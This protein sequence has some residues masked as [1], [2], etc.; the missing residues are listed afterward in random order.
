MIPDTKI[1]IALDSTQ[2]VEYMWCPRAWWYRYK[3]GLAL[4]YQHKTALDYGSII[5]GLLE[6]YYNLR[7]LNSKESPDIHAKAA[8]DMLNTKDYWKDFGVTQEEWQF[9]QM[10]YIQY[11][12]FYRAKGDFVPLVNKNGVPAVEL[13]FS[14]ILFE[15]ESR[16]YIV[17]GRIDLISKF[18]DK[19]F[20]TD[21]K[22]QGTKKDLYGFKTQFLTYAWAT[23]LSD[24]LINYVGTTKEP[25]K[26]TFRRQHINFP[27]HMIDL[28]KDQM[29]GIFNDIYYQTHELSEKA[30]IENSDR[31]FGRRLTSC[32][33]AF[34][35]NPCQYIPIC[36]SQTLEMK[37]SIK[38]F[39]FV[40][41]KIWRPW[42]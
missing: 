26:D 29:T 5:H 15:N 32:A 9:L 12:L 11:M 28:W 25:N 2:I 18:E 38:K 22:T 21:H 37:Q 30:P 34:E 10:R 41:S 4:P 24:G 36:T 16:I 42:E 23:G 40:E 6:T 8:L 1:V 33:G 31:A 20:F 14:K 17:E 19:L 3:E 7:G 35:S 27:K 13:G 39:N